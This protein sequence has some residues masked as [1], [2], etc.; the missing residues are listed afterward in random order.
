MAAYKG[1]TLSGFFLRL[2]VAAVLVFS[3]Y[4]PSEYSY[5]HWLSKNISS[6][7]PWIAL[8]GILLLIGWTI[9]LRATARSLGVFGLMLA[10]AF[11]GVLL[12]MMIDWGW[13]HADSLKAVTYIILGVLCWILA[14]G[15]SWSHIRRRITGQ[16]DVDEVDGDL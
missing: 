8:V 7:T 16:V 10:A 5:Y 4:N 13:F 9:F 14:I 2:L 12:W 1:L 11:I 6:P 3:T 15:V